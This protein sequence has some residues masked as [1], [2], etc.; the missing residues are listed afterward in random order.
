MD[1]RIIVYAYVCMLEMGAR[2]DE[3]AHLLD[4]EPQAAA[5]KGLRGER[6]G[7]VVGAWG[8]SINNTYTLNCGECMRGKRVLHAR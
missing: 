6:F 5:K 8:A 2:S 7:C 3:V 1:L 4:H